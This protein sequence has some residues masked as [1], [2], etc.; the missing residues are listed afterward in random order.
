MMSWSRV[1]GWMRQLAW[2][3]EPVTGLERMTREIEKTCKGIASLMLSKEGI[4]NWRELLAVSDA[5]DK[6]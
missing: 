2:A 5:A 4:S 6:E 3:E 1:V